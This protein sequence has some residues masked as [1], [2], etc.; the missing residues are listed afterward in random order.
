MRT[1]LI[2]LAILATTPALAA[3]VRIDT[4][5]TAI[6]GEQLDQMLQGLGLQA[7]RA[8]DS[9]GNPLFRIQKENYSVFLITDD[10][11]PDGC[12]TLR[13]Y[14]G[15]ALTN[16]PDWQM[17]NGWNRTH[18]HTRAYLDKDGDPVL[19]SDLSLK[20]GATTDAISAYLKRFGEETQAFVTEVG[21]RS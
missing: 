21:F 5:Y 13:L 11:T 9:E 3:E 18:L 16:K 8:D 1:M 4:V 6:E 7:E 14:V 10:C 19:E 12:G 15:F 2:P 20:D 17:V